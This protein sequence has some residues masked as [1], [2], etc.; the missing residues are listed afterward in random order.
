MKV[1]NFPKA[2]L[3]REAASILNEKLREA[4]GK[5]FLLMI[6]GG[7]SMALLDFIDTKL[8]GANS[9]LSML[10]DRYSK[11]PQENNFLT[12]TST[13]FYEKAQ[14]NGASFIDTSLKEDKTLEECGKIFELEIKR[15]RN[16]NPES[17]IY[18][19]I[20][21]GPDGHTAGIMP[22]PDDTSLFYKLFQEE[23]W[24]VGYNAGTKNPL[25]L[26][27]TTTISFIRGQ[28]SFAISYISG[29][30]KRQVLEKL[31]ADNGTLAETPA[32][33]LRE[34]KET[35]IVTDLKL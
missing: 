5:P 22:Y 28:I 13:K 31:L 23:R 17:P 3:A 33:V 19:I 32:R 20:G 27:I 24:A 25:P 34:I 10:D 2:K 4:N 14:K 26:R 8:L 1:I 30:N 12:M 11:N 6:S 7:S 35:V 18:A 21:I 15:W 16:K 9:T 29:E